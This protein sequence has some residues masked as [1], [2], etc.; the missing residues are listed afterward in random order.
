M[1]GTVTS[2]TL[3]WV[4]ID[5]AGKPVRT[6]AGRL[7]MTTKRSRSNNTPLSDSSPGYKYGPV[8]AQFPAALILQVQPATD[9][10]DPATCPC[11]CGSAPGK[12]ARFSIGHDARYKGQLVRA[13]AAQADIVL[14][15]NEGAVQVVPAAEI[16]QYASRFSTNNHDWAR[17]T[18]RG[19]ERLHKVAE[20][21]ARKAAEPKAPKQPKVAT[22]PESEQAPE[23]ASDPRIG[24]SEVIKVGRWDK[25]ATVVAVHDDTLEYE[26]EDKSGES[27]RVT[28][29]A[30]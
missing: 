19:A 22:K 15:D 10:G 13:F 4:A 17:A 18:V 27:H 30:S 7:I 28:R 14:I 5:K 21:K 11:G 29:R 25:Q 26:Y 3:A 8:R 6:R 23:S 16:P 12:K 9:Q 24:R 20:A 2:K 1:L